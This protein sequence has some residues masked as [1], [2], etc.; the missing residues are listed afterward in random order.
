[1]LENS[2]YSDELAFG[3]VSIIMAAYNA[4]KTIANAIDS[5]I[6][7][8]Y[9]NWELIII[10]DSSSDNTKDIIENYQQKDNRVLLIDHS[11]NQGVSVSRHDGL[12]SARGK[13][14]AI[15][16]S[17]DA[18]EKDK[19]EKQIHR[20]QETSGELIYTGS[21][22]MDTDGNVLKW[23]LQVPLTIQY[24]DL[25]KQNI[26][27]NSSVLVER[28][29]YEK[30]FSYGDQMHEDYAIWLQLL[31]D[32]YKAYGVNEPL[33]IYRIDGQ[34]KS[35]NKTKSALMNWN[36]YKYVGLNLFQRCRFMFFYLVRG[37][38]K[39]FSIYLSK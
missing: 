38:H 14:I 32:G 39:Y 26:I 23:K 27:S 33:L 3:K 29:L 16:D 5:V 4:S 30:Y 24:K 13:W 12:T 17:D 15:L 2:N 1:M 10:N 9:I 37:V 7:Q 35:G 19:L 11:K 20:Q 8:T 34:S 36:T 21:A 25:L 18:W 22:F 31:R 28:T 6:K